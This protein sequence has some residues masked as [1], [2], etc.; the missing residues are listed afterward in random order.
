MTSLVLTLAK[1]SIFFLLK[2]KAKVLV[3]TTTLFFF[4]IFYIFLVNWIFKKV[5][6]KRATLGFLFPILYL[7]SANTKRI[8]HSEI[9]HKIIQNVSS[10]HLLLLENTKPKYRVRQSNDCPIKVLWMIIWLPHPV[11]IFTIINVRRQKSWKN[12]P[13][14]SKISAV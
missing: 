7:F 14:F 9:Y 12:N 5:L 11:Q 1:W 8:W 6:K 13:F 2:V 10:K 4:R 3:L